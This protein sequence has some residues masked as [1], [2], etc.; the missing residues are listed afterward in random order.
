M[1]QFQFHCAAYSI[2]FI[3][4]IGIFNATV[5]GLSAFGIL[6]FS[7][8]F[9]LFPNQPNLHFMTAIAAFY[10]TITV[11]FGVAILILIMLLT[12]WVLKDFNSDIK[13]RKFGLKSTIELRTRYQNLIELIDS[14]NDGT[15]W[16][17]FVSNFC[18]IIF[19]CC[20]IIALLS[21]AENDL[22][23]FAK[24]LFVIW[25]SVSVVLFFWTHIPICLLNE[26]RLKTGDALNKRL[27]TLKVSKYLSIKEI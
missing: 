23:L 7:I 17:L 16:N 25:L 10:M 12:F 5:L 27:A 26:E 15:H 20:P 14:L 9:R 1:V 11:Q 8:D 22:I 21:L 19:I 4:I 3:L 24:I 18:T 6:K 13:N 2:C